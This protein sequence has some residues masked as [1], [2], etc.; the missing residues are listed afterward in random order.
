MAIDILVYLSYRL[1]TLS[2]DDTALLTW[3][4]L[5]GQF[6]TGGAG[7]FASKF[8][9]TFRQ[10]IRRAI[11]AYPEARV[12]ITSEGLLMQYSD[13]VDLRRAFVALPGDA[14]RPRPRRG[15][16]DPPPHLRSIT[17]QEGAAKIASAV[18]CADPVVGTDMTA[19]IEP[20]V[21]IASSLGAAQ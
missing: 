20:H 2:R 11:E 15:K 13:P 7:E 5:M 4:D 10:S 16:G 1:P 14:A 21:E 17:A 6:G 12:E 9:D 19:V 8:K 3:R 18:G